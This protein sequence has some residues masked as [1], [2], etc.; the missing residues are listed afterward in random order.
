MA[1]GWRVIPNFPLYEIHPTG[2]VKQILD[3]RVLKL[4]QNNRGYFYHL[5]SPSGRVI[6]MEKSVLINWAYPKE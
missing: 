4:S 3:G 5:E 1:Y 6:A 2:R